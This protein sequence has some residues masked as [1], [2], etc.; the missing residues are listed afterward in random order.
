[1]HFIEII[2]ILFSIQALL[3]VYGIE[4][5][6]KGSVS[7]ISK[8]LMTFFIAST[9]YSGIYFFI[10]GLKLNNSLVIIIFASLLV[11]LLA[12]Y[13]VN[14]K[15]NKLPEYD[16][17]KRSNMM[18]YV[19]I[20]AVFAVVLVMDI[21]PL[22]E[23]KVKEKEFSDYALEYLNNRYGDGDFKI[24]SFKDL[25]DCDDCGSRAMEAYEFVIDTK[26]LD[27]SFN[28]TIEYDKDIFEDTFITEYAYKNNWCEGNTLNVC[29]NDIVLNKEGLKTTYDDYDIKFNIFYSNNYGSKNYGKVPTILDLADE[30]NI[31]FLN[32]N[33]KNYYSDG[34]EK[35]FTQ[36]MI[37][38][39]K[40][41]VNKYSKYGTNNDDLIEFTY[42]EKKGSDILDTGYMKFENDKLYIFKGETPITVDKEDVFPSI[43]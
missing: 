41:Y 16:E 34:E 11:F 23:K 12:Q 22:Y 42:P 40:E 4:K 31:S 10:E 27:K 6:K 1:M 19:T 30:Y 28:L 13:L 29:L 18:M 26:Y 35:E 33:I 21:K 36:L 3:L 14:R 5:R 37:K 43:D 38:L 39:Y 7:F 32:Y 20:I 17:I 9:I 8:Y 25:N 2:C 15:I 24:V